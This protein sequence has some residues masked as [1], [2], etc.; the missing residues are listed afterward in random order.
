M[1]HE[2]IDSLALRVMWSRERGAQEY[3][4][5]AGAWWEGRGQVGGGRGGWTLKA[6]KLS[7]APR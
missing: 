6:G 4:V 1:L 5:R 3:E 7:E 2:Q